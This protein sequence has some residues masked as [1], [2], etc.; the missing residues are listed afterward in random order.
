MVL[1]CRSRGP[2]QI[3]SACQTNLSCRLI[4]RQSM[5]SILLRIHFRPPLEQTTLWP[6]GTTQ[7]CCMFP[8]FGSSIDFK[9]SFVYSKTFHSQ[10]KAKHS[11]TKSTTAGLG[12]FSI[13]SLANN[14]IT[15]YTT[16]SQT[17][18]FGDA[19]ASLHSIK[20]LPVT[21]LKPAEFKVWGSEN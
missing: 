1:T 13:A 9:T 17:V 21:Y 15:C 4:S 12:W 3:C 7:H 14:I 2:H 18:G 20:A 5:V 19:C 8:K 10:K 6:S 16:N 11:K